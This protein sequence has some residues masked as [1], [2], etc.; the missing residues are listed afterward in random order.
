MLLLLLLVVVVVLSLLIYCYCYC[1]CF[2][3][4]SSSYYYY[5]EIGRRRTPGRRSGSWRRIVSA[6]ERCGSRKGTNGVSA[7][8]VTASFM[9]FDTGTFCALPLTYS[10]LFKRARAYLFP[11]SVKIHYFCICTVSV[12]LICPQPRQMSASHGVSW[13]DYIYIYIMIIMIIIIIMIM[14]I[15]IMII[16]MIIIII[17][18]MIIMMMIMII[19]M[20]II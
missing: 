18:I 2:C 11:Q 3:S 9:F 4:S 19:T 6:C 20:I 1:Y 15:V 14:T 16:I 8:G 7:Y 17:M 10:Y 5:Y 13:D 12:D